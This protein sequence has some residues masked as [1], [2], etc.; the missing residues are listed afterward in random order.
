MARPLGG[1]IARIAEGNQPLPRAAMALERGIYRL[2]GIDPAQEQGWA[3]YAISLL[4][5]HAAGIVFLYGLQRLQHLLPFNP[6]ALDAVAPDLAFN[7]AIS[8]ATNTSSQSYAG[9]TTLSHLSQMAGITV[10]S[11]L[12]AASGIAVGQPGLFPSQYHRSR[13][14]DPY[15]ESRAAA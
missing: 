2:A 8:F 7:T 3:A 6:Q 12:S 11:F 14:V 13:A 4:C 10:Q 1:Y 15:R 9:E 5:F